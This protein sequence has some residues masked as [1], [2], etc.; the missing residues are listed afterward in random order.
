MIL[1]SFN[2]LSETLFETML[3]SDKISIL[4]I[5]FQCMS[6]DEE[7]KT[8]RGGLRGER[9]GGGGGGEEAEKMA[10]PHKTYFSTIA[11]TGQTSEQLPHSVHFSS[12]IT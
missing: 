10:P 7:W 12:L 6:H 3:L 2:P 4:N 9:G 5:D 11:S 1:Q 8:E